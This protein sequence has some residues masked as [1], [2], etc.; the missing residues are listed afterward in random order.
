MTPCVSPLLMELGTL[1]ALQEEV[2][3]SPLLLIIVLDIG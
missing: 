2:H 1:T 3:K